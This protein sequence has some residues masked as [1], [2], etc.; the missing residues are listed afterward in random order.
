MSTHNICF[1]GELRKILLGYS[2]LS[3]AMDLT[4]IPEMSL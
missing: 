4:C 2:G 3:G 1:H